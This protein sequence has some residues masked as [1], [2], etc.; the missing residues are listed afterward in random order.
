MSDRKYTKGSDSIRTLLKVLSKQYDVLNSAGSSQTL[1][2][3][4]SAL[5]KF[6]R[7][8]RK[9]DI[10]RIFF[11][12]TTPVP[13]SAQSEL[14]YSDSEL[15]DLSIDELDKLINDEATPRTF[16]ER[17][18]IHRFRVPR[19]SM[20]S[21]SNRRMLVD[22]LSTLIRSEQAHATIDDV[23]RGR[24]RHPSDKSES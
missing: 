8:A 3:D 10:E 5:V 14:Q 11:R 20:R 21:Y 16:L 19:G 15:Y 4:Y 7:S 22:K 17:I 1:L 2:K 24:S 23:A 6:L 12:T 18:A 9:D 13:K